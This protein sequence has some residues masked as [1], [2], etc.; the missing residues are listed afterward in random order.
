M[1]VVA[2]KDRGRANVSNHQLQPSISASPVL[3]LHSLEAWSIV[4]GTVS[5]FAMSAHV[6]GDREYMSPTAVT[7]L[8]RF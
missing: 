8:L 3:P 4:H 5:G 6:F 1:G 7:L 2:P